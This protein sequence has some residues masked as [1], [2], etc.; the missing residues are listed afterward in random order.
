MRKSALKNS[1]PSWI[2]DKTMNPSE[3]EQ[4][5]SKLKKEIAEIKVSV[6]SQLA[7]L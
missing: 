6:K 4:K 7:K 5:I 3:R 1:T 2:S